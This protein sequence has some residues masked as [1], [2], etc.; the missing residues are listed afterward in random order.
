MTDT[1]M[2]PQEE[3]DAL[4]AEYVLGVL[5]LPERMAAEARIKSDTV[6]AERVSAW[7]HRLSGL[8]NGF[9][10]APAPDL[11]PQ[12]EARLFPIATRPRRPWFG[13]LS[14]ALAA[15]AIAG[16]AY[17]AL[18]PTQAPGVVV[19]ELGTVDGSLAY[20]ARHTGT[21]LQVTRV[22]GS[23]PVGAQDHE[24]WI[25]APGAAPVS[26]GLLRGDTLVVDYPQPPVGWILAVSVEPTGGS[27]TGAP[28]G[29]VILTAEI[30]V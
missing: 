14:G 12:I 29:P 30:G 7:E 1:P 4:A 27:P 20:E 25:I 16:A 6:F 8:N 10:E 3:D 23:A 9:D 24:L 15:V 22:A 26:L 17:V 5:D 21:Q 28:T 11:L 19:A 13:W 2:T 18:Q